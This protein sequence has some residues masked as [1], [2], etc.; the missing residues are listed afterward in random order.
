MASS[1]LRL[2]ELLVGLSGIADVGMGM[3]QGEAARA[4]LL[5]V[6]LAE[7]L[8]VRERSDVYYVTLLQ[9]IGCTAY[10]HEAAALLGG[11]ELAVKAAAIRTDFSRPGDVI[12]G[13]LPRLAPGSGGL[14]RLRVAVTAATRAR[15]IVAG[16]S[17]ANCEVAARTAA[18]VG[19]GPGIERGLLDIYEQWDGKGGPRRVRGETIAETARIAQVACLAGLFDRIGGVPAATSAVSRRAGRALDPSV[20]AAF[21]TG[22]A[23]MLGELSGADAL[24]AAV[25]AEPRPVVMVSGTDLDDVCRAFGDA[26]DPGG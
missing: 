11:D 4:A 12:R 21:C 20:A 8:G 3:E 7:A 9:H 16:Y 25:G 22:A 19:L 17:R 5:G 23:A 2:A 26:V 24:P 14:T 6:R 10:A 18:R 13:Y 1:P 15:Q